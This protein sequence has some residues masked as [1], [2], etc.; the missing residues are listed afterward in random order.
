MDAFKLFVLDCKRVAPA[1]AAGIALLS[2]TTLATNT[3]L[4]VGASS[5]TQSAALSWLFGVLLV[6]APYSTRVYALLVAY[7]PPQVAKTLLS[8]ASLAFLTNVIA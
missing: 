3:L 8:W 5:E 7:V 4:R 1:A 6:V 2:S